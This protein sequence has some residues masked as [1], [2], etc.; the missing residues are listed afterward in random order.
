MQLWLLGRAQKTLK[1][2][3]K[4]QKTSVSVYILIGHN[5]VNAH[6]EGDIC[7]PIAELAEDW[8]QRREYQ[9]PKVPHSGL[10]EKDKY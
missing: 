2:K 8:S 6:V 1:G 9:Y 3:I 4:T 5:N 10:S 7:Y